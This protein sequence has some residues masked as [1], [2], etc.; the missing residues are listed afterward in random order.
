[1]ATAPDEQ[2]T[3]PLLRW[4]DLNKS[5][6][7]A[8]LINSMR[9][10]L[11]GVSPIIDRFSMWLLAGTGAAAA[12]LVVHV[13]EVIPFL[14]PPVFKACGFLLVV[15]GAFGFLSK[16]K[17][18]QSQAASAVME[19]IGDAMNTVMQEHAEQARQIDELAKKRQI[20]IQTD[21]DIQRVLTEFLNTFPFWVRLIAARQ[22]RKGGGNATL[23]PAKACI[24]QGNFCLLQTLAFMAF[25]AV[26]FWF[27]HPA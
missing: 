20:N 14:S 27:A 9:G 22:L 15:S 10:S 3:D 16:F 24:W 11:L 17:A 25:I 26:A 19:K 8:N 13:D 6:A 18:I 7:E 12:L 2:Q 4:N 1:M 5:N 21:F 23:K